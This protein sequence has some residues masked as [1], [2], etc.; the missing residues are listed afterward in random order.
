MGDEPGLLQ[1]PA[2]WPLPALARLRAFS[3]IN[4]LDDPRLCLFS[5]SELAPPPPEPEEAILWIMGDV[6]RES[7]NAEDALALEGGDDGAIRP[8]E[9]FLRPPMRR[10]PIF[11]MAPTWTLARPRNARFHYRARIHVL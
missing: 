10:P 1:E 4:P 11:L 6:A 8:T 5:A 3:L 9:S 2:L 7:S